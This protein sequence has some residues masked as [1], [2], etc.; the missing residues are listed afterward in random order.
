MAQDKYLHDQNLQFVMK[1]EF[2]WGV[3]R[4]PKITTVFDCSLRS[5]RSHPSLHA[6]AGIPSPG[7]RSE[8]TERVSLDSTRPLGWTPFQGYRLAMRSPVYKEKR[9]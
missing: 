9:K 7:H 8:R 1:W 4:H 3:A 5:A 6:V 2:R